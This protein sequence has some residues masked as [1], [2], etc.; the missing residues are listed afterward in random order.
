[1]IFYHFKT[2]LADYVADS[3]M[4]TKHIFELKHNNKAFITFPDDLIPL[5]MLKY[6][7]I[8]ATRR[9]KA[10]EVTTFP[11]ALKSEDRWRA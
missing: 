2:S 3:Q 7:M 1:M 9:D 5:I 10:K 11:V 6:T 8:Q 4:Q